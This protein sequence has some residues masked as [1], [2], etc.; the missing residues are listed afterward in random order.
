MERNHI[1]PDMV[2]R[3]FGTLSITI[4]LSTY[5]LYAH[6]TAFRATTVERGETFLIQLRRE[7]EMVPDFFLNFSRLYHSI[8]A[9]C[10]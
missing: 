5:K 9:L 4:Q 3:R 10:M 2:H 7:K 6:S 8:C 1:Y